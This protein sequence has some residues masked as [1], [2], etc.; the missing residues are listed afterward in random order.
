MMKKLSF[1]LLLA[2]SCSIT[3]QSV[4]YGVTG[5]AHIS[6]INKIHD[7][8]K[9]RFGAG[10]GVFGAFPLYPN[11]VFKSQYMFIQPQVEFS[12]QGEKSDVDGLGSQKFDNN[13]IT[14]AVYYK[15]FFHKGPVRSDFFIFGGPKVEF[16]ISD[17]RETTAAYELAYANINKD[18]NINNFGFGLSG[19]VGYSFAE[20][21]EVFGRYDQGLS[22]VY[23]DNKENTFNGVISLGLTYALAGKN[24]A[25]TN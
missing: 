25:A 4:K 15:Y 7:A 20:Q 11:D 16:L 23:P 19:G 5:N 18:Q 3:A 2:L 8:S 1:S 6:G 21:W 12:M 10:V 22:K 14:A 13:Y 9:P 24:S 17:S